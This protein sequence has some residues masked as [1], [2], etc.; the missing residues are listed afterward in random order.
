[1]L[2]FL[3]SSVSA[4]SHHLA[5]FQS[6]NCRSVF[7]LTGFRILRLT[8]FR[9][10]VISPDP[11]FNPHQLPRK[12]QKSVYSYKLFFWRGECNKSLTVESVEK[13]LWI[14]AS[15]AVC[16]VIMLLVLDSTADLDISADV[17]C[18]AILLI[19]LIFCSDCCLLTLDSL[20]F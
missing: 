16:F 4:V 8:G 20:V 3:Q 19:D 14:F 1:V 17:S 5:K 11:R 6:L 7:R 10:P 2:L 9:I 18:I 13:R 15:F 12:I